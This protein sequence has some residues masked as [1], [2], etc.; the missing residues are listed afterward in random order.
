MYYLSQYKCSRYSDGDFHQLSDL[1]HKTK[2][3]KHFFGAFSH[4][5]VRRLALLV[6][7]HDDDGPAEAPDGPGLLHKVLLPGLQAYVVCI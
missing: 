5:P 3:L 6:K 7:G 2:L 1:I 4:P